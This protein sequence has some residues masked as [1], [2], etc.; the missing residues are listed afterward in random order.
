MLEDGLEISWRSLGDRLNSVYMIVRFDE[1]ELDRG[2]RELRRAGMM[3][4]V[5]PQV[6]ELLGFL[7]EQRD[8]VVTKDEIVEHVWNGR[9]VSDA[10]I[11]SRIKDARKALGDDGR[12]QGYIKT[13]HG[14]GFRFIRDIIPEQAEPSQ[15]SHL[16]LMRPGMIVPSEDPR[17]SLIVLPFRSLDPDP[18]GAIL[19]DAVHEDLSTQLARMPDYR[20]IARAAAILQPRTGSNAEEIARSL[21]VNYVITGTVRP[22]GDLVRINAH[23]TEVENGQVIAA[24][25]FDR[26]RSELLDLQNL[27]ILEIANSLGAK[28]NLAEVRRLEADANIDPTAYFHFKQSQLLLEH[29]GWNK[30][31]MSRVIGHLETARKVDPDFAPAISMQALIMG[32]SAPYG[33]VGKSFEE[34]KPEVIDLATEGIEKD[35]HRSTVLGW[36]GC[37][38]CDVGEPDRG[39]PYLERAMEL[40]PSNAQ[41]RAALGWALL[42]KGE[43]ARAIDLFHEAI[44]ISPNLP[45]HAFWL[46][47]L[48]TA[49]A[50]NGDHDAQK[51]TLNAAIKLDPTLALPYFTLSGVAAAAGDREAADAYAARAKSLI[52]ANPNQA[53]AS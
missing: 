45:G 49:Q 29:R 18:S 51:A 4:P 48:A 17:P 10:A 40:D 52:D 20:V 24:L 3:L 15:P 2:C 32:L 1:F 9:I 42:Q 23:V 36:S 21:G 16:S 46:C 41:S 50:G 12:T 26:K 14:T 35:P 8:R 34:V 44:A 22:A 13:V 11:S 19:A 6:F 47:G 28:I 5:E 31:A 53:G 38:Y 7:V 43:H 39:K 37:A 30:S 25:T 33:L 27:L